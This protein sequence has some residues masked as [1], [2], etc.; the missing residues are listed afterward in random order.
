MVR[1]VTLEEDHG[2]EL[3]SMC[4]N[5]YLAVEAR[6]VLKYVAIVRGSCSTVLLG[7]RLNIKLEDS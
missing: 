6:T 1:G 2:N 5:M 7:Y 3:K 4:A